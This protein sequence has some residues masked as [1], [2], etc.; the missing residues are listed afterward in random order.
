MSTPIEYARIQLLNRTKREL[1]AADPVLLAGQ[2][3]VAD[4]GTI[5]PD[6]RFGDGVRPW[7]ALP[8]FMAT[9][10]GGG[11]FAPLE[12]QNTINGHALLRVNDQIVPPGGSV[13]SMGPG[14][15][16]GTG[17]SI[18]TLGGNTDGTV[19]KVYAARNTVRDCFAADIHGEGWHYGDPSIPAGY[20][21]PI[22]GTCNGVL[23]TAGTNADDAALWV[24]DSGNGGLRPYHD[25]LKLR[26]DG[27]GFLGPDEAH[28]FY[29]DAQG[30]FNVRGEATLPGLNDMKDVS[31]S[32]LRLGDVLQWN[33]SRWG[34]VSRLDGYVTQI[35]AG[36][37]L[38]GGVI[39]AT[40]TIALADTIVVPGHYTNAEL[41]VDPQGRITYARSGNNALAGLSDVALTDPAHNQVLAYDATAHKWFNADLPPPPS[42]ETLPDVAV[43]GKTGGQVL[44]WD[45]EA[46]KWVNAAPP[47][48]T[49]ADLSDVVVSGEAQGEV[50]SWNA[51]AGKW[52]NSALP[53]GAVIALETLQDVHITDPRPNQVLA[54]D[55]A[56]WVNKTATSVTVAVTPPADPEPGWLWWDSVGG[57][58]FVWYDD[59]TT[60]QWVIANMGGSGSWIGPNDTNNLSWDDAGSFTFA[61]TAAGTT[62]N[63]HSSAGSWGE[64]IHVAPGAYGLDIK[65]SDTSG[66][67]LMWIR[68][69]DGRW[70]FD[71][72]SD[73]SGMLGRPGTF[74]QW[75][76][77]VPALQWTADGKFGLL[78]PPQQ[79]PWHAALT[80]HTLN[81]YRAWG[82][83]I[84]CTPT[85]GRGNGLMIKADGVQADYALYVSQAPG[86]P[87][88]FTIAGTG[89]VQCYTHLG[90]IGRANTYAAVITAEQSGSVS[91][92]LGVRAGRGGGTCVSVWN[93][94]WNQQ[95]FQIDTYGNVNY[96]G[97]IGQFSSVRDKI[98]VHPVTRAQ[99]RAALAALRPVSF[100]RPQ[101]KPGQVNYG[102]IA[103]E[104]A[105]SAPQFV[106]YDDAGLPLGVN[107]SEVLLML[108]P[109]V[110]QWLEERDPC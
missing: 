49:L 108:V 56:N 57:Q 36:T 58:L 46:E 21:G 44:A 80:I 98:D 37:G 106:T 70:I 84:V 32:G 90:V 69:G 101:G 30:N 79:S 103:E 110:Q 107:L 43:T 1:S 94:D 91:Y 105:Q 2:A 27:S 18:L 3:A 88:A 99:A 52:M 39:T 93:A 72:N 97:G 47:A 74:N 77:E 68:D 73:G 64:R 45:A 82:M 92:G 104:V 71:V 31:I 78:G 20:Q 48:G 24:R 50:L 28:C 42:L 65:A 96:S 54:Y 13:I 9:G 11:I 63:V 67:Y 62:V 89:E 100:R 95:L 38:T 61:A 81:D 14:E 22:P 8:S 25:F 109:V 15:V 86:G 17:Y 16:G 83:N 55:G 5:R 76:P 66:N 29:W 19:F 53:G 75:S 12:V 59:G 35:T 33:G 85:N 4:V 51:A 26:G 102:L 23:I 41:T 7:S 40:G 60:G 10:L 34:N 6:L 87:E